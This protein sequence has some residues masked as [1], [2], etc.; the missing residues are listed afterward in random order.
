MISPPASASALLAS[1]RGEGFGIE[2][3]QSASA[4]DG[5][6]L[7]ML[8]VVFFVVGM[9]AVFAWNMKRRSHR[10]DP[11]LEFLDRLAQEEKSKPAA[12][13]PTTP[14]EGW[15]RPADWWKKD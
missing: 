7:V 8:G 2:N 12:G 9:L 15:E 1:L 13:E 10:P 5:A 4:A 14:A 6:A 3:G 11:T